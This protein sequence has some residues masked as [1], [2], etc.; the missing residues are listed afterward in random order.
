MI[1]WAPFSPSLWP[2]L[3]LALPLPLGLKCGLRYAGSAEQRESPRRGRS[4]R[5]AAGPLDHTLNGKG[6]EG[7]SL[8]TQRGRKRQAKQSRFCHISRFFQPKGGLASHQCWKG[9]Q[10]WETQ[11]SL[12]GRFLA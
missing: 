2:A 4:C 12:E 5:R 3:L 10:L 7:S 9:R 6:L 1:R 8:S 11:S